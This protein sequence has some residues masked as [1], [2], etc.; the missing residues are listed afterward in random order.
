MNIG[1]EKVR[2]YGGSSQISVMDIFEGRKLNVDR[3]PNLLL[4]KKAVGFPFE[5]AVTN[6]VNAAVDLLSEMTAAERSRIK[7]FITASESSVDFGKSLSTFQYEFLD[8]PDDCR[9]FEVKQACYSL[10][11]G[12]QT[13]VDHIRC[14]PDEKVLIVGTDIARSSADAAYGEP[15]Q[16]CG[17]IAVLMSADPTVLTVDVGAYGNHGF[18]VFDSF[19]PNSEEEMGD[20]DLSL[21]S[22]LDCLEKSYGKY[23]EKIDAD[24]NNTDFAY[25]FFHTPFGGLVKGAHRRLVTSEKRLPK[26]EIDEDFTKRVLPSLTFNKQIG[27]LYGSAVY[28]AL[29]SLLSAVDTLTCEKRIGI[30]SYGSG[31]CSEFYSGVIDGRSSEYVKGLNIQ[32]DLDRRYMLSFDEYVRLLDENRKTIFGL[33][34]F[35]NQYN[36]YMDIFSRVNRGKKRLYLQKAEDY[37]RSYAWI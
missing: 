34:S 3:F 29:C 27:N 30:F 26:K 4:E 18:G 5:D 32:A 14:Y 10:T 20:S 15:S 6:G 16:G 1:I 36:D 35:E 31:C 23:K 33:R 9:M 24:I 21:M 28:V 8:L 11:A 22:Y 17:A 12:L 25:F 2:I 37:K 7:T 19:R 13:A